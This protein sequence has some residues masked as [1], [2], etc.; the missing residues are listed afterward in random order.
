MADTLVYRAAAEPFNTWLLSVNVAVALG[1]VWMSFDSSARLDGMQLAMEDAK[2]EMAC[3]QTMTA[4]QAL[5]ART[6]IT[7]QAVPHMYLM[8][9]AELVQLLLRSA[10]CLG[11]RGDVGHDAVVL[12]DRVMASPMS[13]SVPTGNL[14]AAACLVVAAQQVG[15]SREARGV[16]REWLI[17][18]ACCDLDFLML[19]LLKKWTEMTWHFLS[20]RVF[21]WG[22]TLK[23]LCNRWNFNS[24]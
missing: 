19:G 22:M 5:E 21:V 9:R 16:V 3:F 11:M 8:Q 12:M 1:N 15:R 18:G 4:V 13:S 10:P 24:G 14:L 17:V 2:K 20:I 6:M 7:A 23:W